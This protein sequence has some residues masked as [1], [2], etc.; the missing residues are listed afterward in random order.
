MMQLK[1]LGAREQLVLFLTGSAG[2]GKTTAV[3]LAQKL[4]F[5]FCT[6]IHFDRDWVK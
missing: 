6:I 2:A 4:C 3:K 1:G 5:E